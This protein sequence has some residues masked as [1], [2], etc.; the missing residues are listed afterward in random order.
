MVLSES[1]LKI[2]LRQK[3]Y[4]LFLRLAF[5]YTYW[6]AGWEFYNY[7]RRVEILLGTQCK[8]SYWLL[9]CFYF[10][11][12]EGFLLS[13]HI[14]HLRYLEMWINNDGFP[15][16][17]RINQLCYVEIWMNNKGFLLFFHISHQRYLEIWMNNKRISLVFFI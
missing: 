3:F 12:Y 15:F 1:I 14:N 9:F 13:F 10:G 8:S 7:T 4:M 11:N 16:S 2:S 5:T 6:Q 17:L